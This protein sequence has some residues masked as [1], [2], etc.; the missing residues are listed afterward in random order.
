MDFCEP[1][2]M[3]RIFA[4][5]RADVLIDLVLGQCSRPL[6]GK[7]IQ[8]RLRREPVAP[9]LFVEVR[10]LLTEFAKRFAEDGELVSRFGARQPHPLAVYSGVRL[11]HQRRRTAASTSRGENGS[12]AT[13]VSSPFEAEARYGALN[14]VAPGK[15]C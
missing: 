7:P 14:S 2:P 15:Q 11:A 8:R 12:P 9:G 3:T 10:G 5:D 6:I 1:G 13:N 4:Q